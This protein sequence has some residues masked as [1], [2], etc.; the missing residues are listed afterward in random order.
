MIYCL[1]NIH[2]MQVLFDCPQRSPAT[3]S[4]NQLDYN[5]DKEKLE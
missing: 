5:E 3:R 2:K 1:F 4:Q